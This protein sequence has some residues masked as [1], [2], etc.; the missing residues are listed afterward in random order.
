MTYSIARRYADRVFFGKRVGWL[1][2][3]SPGII[4]A[5]MIPT[6]RRAAQIRFV[7]FMV[8]SL[9][10]GGALWLAG[11]M[12]DLFGSNMAIVLYNREISKIQIGGCVEVKRIGGV[13]RYG[14]G[15]Q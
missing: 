6:S 11:H 13:K 4:N 3:T 14:R 2:C 12:R 15:K 8:S 10:C 1:A 9:E 5:Q 7:L